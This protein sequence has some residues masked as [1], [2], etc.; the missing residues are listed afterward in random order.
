MISKF[1]LTLA[2][3]IIAIMVLKQRKNVGQATNSTQ[4][5]VTAVAS[6]APISDYRVAAYLF[7]AVMIS[8][9]GVVYFFDWQEDH[10]IITVTLHGDGDA[11]PVIYQVYQYQL[12][13]RSFV[14]TDGIVVNI[15][16]NERMVVE[17]LEP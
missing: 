13:S 10:R 4:S 11:E 9:A 7:L 5:T 15:A 3:I 17:G 8:L 14:T 1:L 16:S 12:Q 6:K 2:V